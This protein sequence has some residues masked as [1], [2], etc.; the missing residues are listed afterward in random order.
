MT[1]NKRIRVDPQE[2]RDLG[3]HFHH[4][5]AD[6]QQIVTDL[7]SATA[8]LDTGAWTGDEAARLTARFAEAEVMG[9]RRA[10][11]HAELGDRLCRAADAFEEADMATLQ[12]SMGLSSG[13]LKLPSGR[14]TPPG[15]TIPTPLLPP[16]D[17]VLPLPI[18]IVIQSRLSGFFSPW[19]D[20]LS[21]DLKAEYLNNP[22]LMSYQT[23]MRDWTVANW[24]NGEAPLSLDN[25]YQEALRVAGDPG[26]ALL[27]CHNVTKAFARGGTAIYWQRVRGHDDLYTDGVNEYQIPPVT[28]ENK[29]IVQ[30]EGFRKPSAFY[31][32][33][34][35]DEFGTDD[36]GDWY[37]YYVMATAAYYGASGRAT[38][39]DSDRGIFDL[40]YVDIVGDEVENLVVQ[41]QQRSGI[42]SSNAY[43]GWLWANSLSFLEGG[44]Y[45]SDQSSVNQET[46]VHI[47]GAL[48]GLSLAGTSPSDGWQWLVPESSAI[49]KPNLGHV[50]FGKTVVDDLSSVVYGTINPEN[51]SGGIIPVNVED[52]GVR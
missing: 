47:Q 27:V 21:N 6:I 29:D 11:A 17:D 3:T 50:I 37:H 31:L 14:G 5:S 10:A 41:M 8:G 48:Y 38:L 9:Q 15:D 2:L 4:V 7:R 46:Q 1:Q 20:S 16:P 34:S 28:D 24:Q 39:G 30:P 43:D 33:F 13:W 51:L 18:E 42:E 22:Q 52:G 40:N 49:G 12:E 25:L 32:M 19:E 44:V 36:P 26:T 45:G 23:H 35:A